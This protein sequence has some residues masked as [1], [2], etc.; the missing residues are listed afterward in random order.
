[1]PLQAD[2]TLKF[3]AKDFALKVIRGPILDIES[4]YNTYR[5]PGLPPGPI[6]TPSKTTI[7]AVLN[8]ANT[9]FLFFVAR[10]NLRGHL[11]S[12]TFDE[13]KT[14]ANDYRAADRLRQEKEKNA[15][16]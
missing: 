4:P 5:N 15:D 11:F 3:A 12:V 16:D 10:P 9:D 2:P 13:H 8:P 14:K 7:D 6:S 1:M